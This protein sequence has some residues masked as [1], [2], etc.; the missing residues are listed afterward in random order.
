EATRAA[1]EGRVEMLPHA[2]VR[3]PAMSLAASL[4]RATP[5]GGTPL[6]AV[7]ARRSTTAYSGV[8]AA[9][10]AGHGYVPLNRTFPLERTWAMLQRSGCRSLIVD[11]ESELRLEAI[12]DLSEE[13][14]LIILPERTDTSYLRSR[15]SRHTI[16]GASDLEQAGNFDE[17]PVSPDS[18]AY[19]LFTSG[20]TGIP[21][22][23]MVAHQ[24][25][26]HLVSFMTARYGISED[27]RFSQDR[28]STRLN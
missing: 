18:I 17:K 20:S 4:E 5:P 26:A 3:N 8:L 27:D 14:L 15:W 16:L 7:F 21:K 22:G 9:L 13:P 6:T 12:L 28:N 23:V 11:A 19:L 10:L 1:A 25:V 2:G 24:N